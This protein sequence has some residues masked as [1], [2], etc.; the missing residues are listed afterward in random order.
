MT[1]KTAKPFGAPHG[2]PI[3]VPPPP[4][5]SAL[6]APTPPKI[7][8]RQT[9]GKPKPAPAPITDNQKEIVAAFA[10]AA[11]DFSIALS[12]FVETDEAMFEGVPDPAHVFA[13]LQSLGFTGED[14]G[15]MMRLADIHII[16]PGLAAAKGRP[17]EPPKIIDMSSSN[18]S[19]EAKAGLDFI[20]DLPNNKQLWRAKNGDLVVIRRWQSARE[21]KRLII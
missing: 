10:D 1:A 8:T 2:R 20:R 16:Q 14:I 13:E 19:D 11:L 18:V 17:K 12:R 7:E 5:P 21:A 4:P 6:A 9:T 15:E 3:T